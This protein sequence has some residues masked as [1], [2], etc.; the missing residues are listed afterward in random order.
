MTSYL[1]HT[2]LYFYK[3]YFFISSLIC[4]STN[5][6]RIRVNAFYLNIQ[7]IFLLK[8]LNL[9]LNLLNIFFQS[10]KNGLYKILILLTRYLFKRRIN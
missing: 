7:K 9:Y 8:Q 1:H 5:E 10:N 4:I 3:I 6:N 2:R